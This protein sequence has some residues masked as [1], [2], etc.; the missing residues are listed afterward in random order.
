MSYLSRNN[1]TPIAIYRTTHGLRQIIKLDNQVD[2]TNNITALSDYVNQKELEQMTKHLSS[3]ELIMLER[4]IIQGNR[5]LDPRLVDL[6]DRLKNIIDNKVNKEIVSNEGEYNIYPKRDDI[7]Y[8]IGATGSGKSTSIR[9]YL[10]EYMKLYPEVKKIF[11]F[12]DIETPDK[13]FE[14]LPITKI[15]LDAQ[16]YQNPIKPEELKNSVVIF[17]DVD[18]IQ[19]KKIKNAIVELKGSCMKQGVS[20][21]GITC[22][23]TNHDACEGASTKHAITNARYIF[24]YPNGGTVGLEYLLKK[25][26]GFSKEEYKKIASL[27]SRVVIIHKRAPFY[28]VHSNGVFL[29]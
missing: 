2:N 29:L 22:I 15:K 25:K 17:D 3:R 5:P 1:G 8:L 19:D 13:V 20:K 28:V 18:S 11:L 16:I 6:Y 21:E 14:G 9:K 24:I 26:I 27:R 10:L 7:L 4:H 23:V 12:T